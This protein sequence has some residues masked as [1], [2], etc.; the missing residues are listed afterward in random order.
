MNRQTPLRQK[1]KARKPLLK[2][3]RTKKQAG[4]KNNEML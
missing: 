2:R 1:I 4:G 3:L